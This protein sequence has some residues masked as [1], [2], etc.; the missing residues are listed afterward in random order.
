MNVHLVFVPRAAHVS[1]Q[2]VKREPVAGAAVSV[3]SRGSNSAF[4]QFGPHAMPGPV[5][6][7]TPL[8]LLTTVTTVRGRN[9]GMAVLFAVSLNAQ[10]ALVAPPTRHVTPVHPVNIAPGSAV[11]RSTTAVP[12]S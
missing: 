2:P 8:A 9:V 5:T 7:P 11:A 10:L 1:P 3:M 12:K 4:E 6:V